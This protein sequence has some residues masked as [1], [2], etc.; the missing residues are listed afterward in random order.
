MMK[1]LNRMRTVSLV[2]AVSYLLLVGIA[3][4]MK[5]WAGMPIFVKVLGMAH[6]VLF[7]LLL[8]LLMRVKFE[9]RWPAL[10]LA[11][12]GFASLL[13]IVPFVLDGRIRGWIAASEES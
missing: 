2:E 7:L 1:L 6:G 4:P 13:P 10:R 3:M 11:L 8:W 5:Y 9:T 12:I